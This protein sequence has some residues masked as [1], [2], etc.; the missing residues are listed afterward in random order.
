LYFS[1]LLL[2]VLLQKLYSLLSSHYLTRIGFVILMVV[3]LCLVI[4]TFYEFY[5]LTIGLKMTQEQ[6]EGLKWKPRWDF[7]CQKLGENLNKE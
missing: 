2:G 7:N 4:E 3:Y 1:L 6:C 5:P